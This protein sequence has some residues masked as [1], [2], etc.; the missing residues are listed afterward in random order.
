MNRHSE[1]RKADVITSKLLLSLNYLRKVSRDYK[2]KVKT[3]TYFKFQYAELQGSVMRAMENCSASGRLT[4]HSIRFH[5]L[6]RPIGF[7]FLAL[8]FFAW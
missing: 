4:S 2:R 8:V 7:V 6:L 1:T 3:G 5:T